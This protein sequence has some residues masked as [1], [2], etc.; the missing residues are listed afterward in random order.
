MLF[1]ALRETGVATLAASTSRN[2]RRLARGVEQLE[3]RLLLCANVPPDSLEPNDSITAATNLGTGDQS[4]SN[5]TISP[6]I[7][8]ALVGSPDYFR[9]TASGS[10]TAN[11]QILFQHSQGDL[12]LRVLNV[13]QQVIASSASRTD[14]ESASFDVVQGQTYFVHV[15]GFR[16]VCNPDYD[17]SIDGPDPVRNEVFNIRFEPPSPADLANDE[18]VDITF[19]YTTDVANGVRIFARPMSKGSLSPNYA[20]HGSPLYPAPAGSGAGFFT[21]I[22]GTVHVDQVRVQMWTDGLTSLLYETLV[23]VDYSFSDPGGPPIITSSPSASVPEN[24]TSVMTVTATDPDGDALIFYTVGGADAAHFNIG[25]ANGAL[26]FVSA[27]DFEHPAD[28]DGNNI[29]EVR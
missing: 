12:D 28:A 26:S 20:A 8:A 11:V 2:R 13:E 18:R 27:P 19:S 10:G 9:W 3:P 21:I 25:N 23:A 16:G 24:N 7:G 15:F 14:N 17:L 4:L 29:Y 22:S 5:L 1:K 6:V